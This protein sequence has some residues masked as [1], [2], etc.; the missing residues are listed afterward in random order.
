MLG[1]GDHIAVGRIDHGHTALGGRVDVNIVHADTC[2]AHRLEALAA[3]LQQVGIHRRAGACYDRIV[4]FRLVQKR[5]RR[6]PQLDINLELTPQVIDARLV[7]R[8]RNKYLHGDN[9]RVITNYELR[10]E[11]FA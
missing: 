10:V 4:L 3:R 1:G 5:G 6:Q 7:Q 2:P 8:F 9:L 11:R